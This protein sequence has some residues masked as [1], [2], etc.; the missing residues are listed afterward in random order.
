MSDDIRTILIAATY[1]SVAA[2]IAL[3]FFWWW[4]T[5]TPAFEREF[6]IVLWSKGRDQRFVIESRTV[7][8]GVRLSW[9]STWIAPSGCRCC[10]EFSDMDEAVEHMRHLKN[11]HDQ[12]RARVLKSEVINSNEV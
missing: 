4:L 1:M 2:A 11:A 7:V 10:A 12:H 3:G 8:G 9:T 5:E 6:R